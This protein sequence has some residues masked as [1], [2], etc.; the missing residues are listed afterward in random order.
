MNT[1]CRS[2]PLYISARLT[3][4]SKRDT[5]PVLSDG[6]YM[7]VLWPDLKQG[8][9]QQRRSYVLQKFYEV[10]C[11]SVCLHTIGQEVQTESGTVGQRS[12]GCLVRILGESFSR[13]NSGLQL[14][15]KQEVTPPGKEGG[16]KEGED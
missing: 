3:V 8:I 5:V 7:L 11:D 1:G 13:F 15:Q 16:N 4:V 6:A 10:W 2:L 12:R 14:L 9:T